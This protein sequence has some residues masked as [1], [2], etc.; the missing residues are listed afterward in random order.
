MKF[1]HRV[2]DAILKHA[3]HGYRVLRMRLLERQER[4]ILRH[5]WPGF[6]RACQD[7]GR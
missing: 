5:A 3:Q 2:E 4:A 1:L 6:P 7:Q